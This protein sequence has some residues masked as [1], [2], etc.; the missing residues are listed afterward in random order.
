ML[1]PGDVPDEP[2]ELICS[3]RGCR[4]PATRGLR[5]NNP[6]LHA[7]QRRKTWLVCEDH[8]NSLTQFLSMRSFL[9]ETVSVADLPSLDA[10]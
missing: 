4:A 8:L 3:A 7:P 9:R 2:S 1:R 6:T 5:W 10:R